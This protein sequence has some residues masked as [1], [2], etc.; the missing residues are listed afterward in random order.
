MRLEPHK[1]IS[2]VVLAVV[3]FVHRSISVNGMVAIKPIKIRKAINRDAPEISTYLSPEK[4]YN[5]FTL[6]TNANGSTTQVERGY[7][8]EQSP[9]KGSKSSDNRRPPPS[10]DQDNASNVE[11]HDKVSHVL[12]I[13]HSSL[14]FIPTRL[15]RTLVQSRSRKHRTQTM[16]R[17]RAKYVIIQYTIWIL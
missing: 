7:L 13:F 1:R 8:T 3:L 4:P 15:P 17:K 9:T 14:T 10:L 6:F 12:S 5:S 2:S 16:D 11:D